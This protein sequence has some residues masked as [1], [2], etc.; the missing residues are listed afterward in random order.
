MIKWEYK[1]T[2]ADSFDDM[3]KHLNDMGADGW[4]N[5][6]ISFTD[7]GIV[8]QLFW[9]RQVLETLIPC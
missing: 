9:K 8:E 4:E 2:S 6:T 3:N 5:Y 7:R 1:T